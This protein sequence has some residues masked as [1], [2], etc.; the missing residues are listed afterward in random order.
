MTRLETPI[1]PLVMCQ[2]PEKTVT[3]IFRMGYPFTFI[4]RLKRDFS[5]EEIT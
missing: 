4:E 1:P 3:K 5:N 2:G